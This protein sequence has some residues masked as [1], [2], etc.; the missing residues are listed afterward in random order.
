MRCSVRGAAE[1]L[2]TLRDGVVEP[3]FRGGRADVR[4][5]VAVIG[6]GIDCSHPEIELALEEGRIADCRG[7]PESLD[8][9]EDFEGMGTYCVSVVMRTMPWVSIYVARVVDED[10]RLVKENRYEAFTQV[11]PLLYNSDSCRRLIGRWNTKSISFV[12]HGVFQR[13]KRP[14]S[15]QC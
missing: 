9:A 6:A 15:K 12:S 3:L 5:R 11:N 1:W 8:P 7:F 10:G 13:K 14:S 4:V 2:A